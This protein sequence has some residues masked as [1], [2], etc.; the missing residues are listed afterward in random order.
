MIDSREEFPIS[1]HVWRWSKRGHVCF[2]SGDLNST[3]QVICIGGLTDGLLPCP[4]IT[5][6]N[7]ECSRNNY[8]LIQPLLS[9]SYNGYGTG[10]LKK[11]TDEIAELIEH[12]IDKHN[13]RRFA[14]IGHSTGCQNA[15]HF[16]RYGPRHLMKKLF[17]IVLQAPVSDCESGSMNDLLPNRL[18]YAN[19]LKD[20]YGIEKCS[21]ILMPFDSHYSPITV[22]R[23][24]SLFDRYGDDDYFSS[25][26]TDD[27]F[28][29]HFQHFR[30]DD[31]CKHIKVLIAYSLNDEYVP[32]YVDKVQLTNRICQ[33]IGE[34]AS[35]LLLPGADHALYLPSISISLD[36]GTGAKSGCNELVSCE[37][38]V[39]NVISLFRSII[40][41]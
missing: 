17:A 18:I 19:S 41:S 10:S 2:A 39:S 24:L 7:L 21:E 35:I 31:T 25:Y 1:G 8:C 27:D 30:L 40:Y 4:W 3:I 26:F 9:S 11:D 14:L 32:D 20:E 36:N 38:F 23:F 33:A 5:K 6:L 28:E 34:Q 22:Y 15:I 29:E 37:L 12:M 16:S 13:C